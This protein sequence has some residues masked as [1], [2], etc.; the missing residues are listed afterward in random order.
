MSEK[1]PS[2]LLTG[3]YCTVPETGASA[4]DVME[5][6]YNEASC[7]EFDGTLDTTR[8]RYVLAVLDAYGYEI[9]E[10]GST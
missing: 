3:R 2:S 6:A 9:V 5:A 10:K 4:H 8:S 7:H 1:G